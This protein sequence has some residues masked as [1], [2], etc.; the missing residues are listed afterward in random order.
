MMKGG[1]IRGEQEEE[2]GVL[3]DLDYIEDEVALQEGNEEVEGRY[4]D[5]PELERKRKV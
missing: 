4:D 2:D 3:K 5:F 1:L